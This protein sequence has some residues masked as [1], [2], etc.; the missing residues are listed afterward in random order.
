M[1]LILVVYAWAFASNV[2]QR[3]FELELPK[4]EGM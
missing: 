1:D 3:P 2:G 4:V